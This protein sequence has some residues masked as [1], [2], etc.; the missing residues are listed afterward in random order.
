MENKK[1]NPIEERINNLEATVSNVYPPL[2][3]WLEYNRVMLVRVL[4]QPNKP[5]ESDLYDTVSS[6]WR[7]LE[8]LDTKEVRCDY[9]PD[10]IDRVATTVIHMFHT[11]ETYKNRLPDD[12]KE[13][14]YFAIG[15]FKAEQ[16]K[17]RV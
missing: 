14:G 8:W 15:Q 6:I 5:G 10:V 12:V 16:F 17:E 1:I 3:D 13:S 4:S 9:T 11:Y 2:Y 7:D